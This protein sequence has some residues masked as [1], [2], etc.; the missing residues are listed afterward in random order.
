M[1]KK[2]TEIS[3]LP[4][5]MIGSFG[6]AGIDW[7]HS[8]LDN[9]P[10]AL[11][12]PAFSFFRTLERI[13]RGNEFNIYKEKNY[14]IAKL[15]SNTFYFD[16]A[17]QL[18]RRKF[19]N[20]ENQRKDFENFLFDYL[21][22]SKEIDIKKKLFFGIHYA[23]AKIYNIDLS[24]KKL[25]ITHEHVC[26]HCNKYKKIF[27]SKFII[28]FRDPRATLAGEILRMRNSNQD[29]KIN[30]LQLDTMLLTMSSA[31]NFLKKDN[32]SEFIYPLV[33]EKMVENL[34]N[35]MRDLAKWLGIDYFDSMTKQTFMNKEWLG[36]SAY[37]A[38]DEL[39]EKAP[40]NFY[41]PSEVERRWR[42]ILSKNEILF[43]EVIYR[44]VMRRFNFKKDNDL[45]FIKI[46]NGYFYF[47]FL[48][49]H[50]QKFYFNRYLTIL[51][52]LLRRL[53]IRLL[54][55]KTQYFFNFK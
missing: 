46:I 32:K 48:H 7:I 37:L 38:K 19:I 36:E 8:L 31:Y 6:H 44:N 20:D 16:K 26:W 21:E 24:K 22:N 18:K 4:V 53:T 28:I 30:S 11:L 1:M 41:H 14:E 42:S 43:I 47:Y 52:N 5:I 45:N 33:N 27:N 3:E 50:Q 9:H 17:Y 51:R 10:Q 29:K 35:E 54:G 2:V 40:K 25:I 39:E 15:L 23:F 55:S 12:M 34:Q 49:Q 13:K